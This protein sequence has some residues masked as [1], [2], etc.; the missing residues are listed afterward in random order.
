M[1]KT[2]H[3]EIARITKIAEIENRTRRDNGSE[4]NRWQMKGLRSPDLQFSVS[5]ASVVGFQRS[6]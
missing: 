3:R 4:D 5:P 2:Q 1:W 6:R